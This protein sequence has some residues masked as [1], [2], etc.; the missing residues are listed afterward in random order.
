MSYII[1]DDKHYKNIANAIRSKLLVDTQYQPEDM[2]IAINNIPSSADGMDSPV[3][4]VYFLNPDS[5]N[6][7]T[8]CKVVGWKLDNKAASFPI[9]FNDNIFKNIEKIEFFECDFKKIELNAFAGCL[10]LTTI[11]LPDSLTM[12]NNSAFY[13]CTS[14]TAI[15]FSNSLISIGTNAFK[16]CSS[17]TAVTL[18]NSLTSIEASGFNGC[19]SLTTITLPN[20]LTKINNGA[21]YN[22]VKLENVT[23]EDGFNCNNLDLSP[24]TKFTR[25]TIVS[26]LIALADRTG[27][28]AYKLIIGATNIAKLTEEDIAIATA[29]NWTLA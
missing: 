22:C 8:K 12:I 10:R 20:S 24:S 3:M 15:T 29:K 21:F 2:S 5:N 1:T 25:E 4:G 11:T 16:G 19:I 28:T 6:K 7:P 27:L 23:I 14:L 18:P 17:L 26:W 13:G 9:V